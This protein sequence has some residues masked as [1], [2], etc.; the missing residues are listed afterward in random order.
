[1]DFDLVVQNGPKTVAGVDGING[2]DFAM[3]KRAGA[4]S[5]RSA[6]SQESGSDKWQRLSLHTLNGWHSITDRQR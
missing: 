1:M 2:Y 6:K 4:P 3:T 5:I